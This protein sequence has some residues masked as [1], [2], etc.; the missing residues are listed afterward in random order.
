M[1]ITENI[2]K[3]INVKACTIFLLDKSRNKLDVSASHGLSEVYLRKGPLDADKS[4]AETLDGQIVLIHDTSDDSRVQYPEEAKKEGIASVLSVPM[5]VKGQIIGVLR[6]YTA[7]QRNISD[8][9]YKLISGLADM[10][11]IA[12]DNARMYDHLKADHESLIA[13]TNQWFEFGKMQ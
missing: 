6:I 5:T 7:E 2:V 8:D 13:D 11:G 4:I 9:E 12:I 10:G 1:L 3:L